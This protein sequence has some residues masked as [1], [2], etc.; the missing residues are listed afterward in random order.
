MA[1]AISTI[2]AVHDGQAADVLGVMEITL[3]ARLKR[4]DEAVERAKKHPCE[5]HRVWCLL[6]IA[7][8]EFKDG[9]LEPARRLLLE[10]SAASSTVADCPRRYTD[11]GSPLWEE[12]LQQVL[13]TES[14][15]NAIALVAISQ[16]SAG[17]PAEAAATARKLPDEESRASALLVVAHKQAETGHV[18]HARA[19]VAVAKA[20]ARKI[21]E[22]QEKAK[23]LAVIAVAEDKLGR[24]EESLR[25][26]AEALS[27]ANAILPCGSGSFTSQCLPTIAEAELAAGSVAEAAE[28][29]RAMPD[30]EKKRSLLEDIARR[31]EK[32]R[33]KV[34]STKLSD[35]AEKLPAP[36][37]DA[38]MTAALQYDAVGTLTNAGKYAEAIAKARQ[39]KDSRYKEWAY[40]SIASA[41][42][43]AKLMKELRETLADW[44][45]AAR[46]FDDPLIKEDAWRQITPYVAELRLARELQSTFE[47]RLVLARQLDA[48]GILV[49]SSAWFREQEVPALAHIAVDQA[50]FGRLDDALRT[51]DMI[52]DVHFKFLTLHAIM[53]DQPDNKPIDD[54]RRFLTAA[55][56][57]ARAD[58]ENRADDF[59]DIAEFQAANGFGAEASDSLDELLSIA[60]KMEDLGD[61]A[62][63]LCQVA[64]ARGGVPKHT[65]V[66]ANRISEQDKARARPI[67]REAV[68]SAKGIQNQTKR[69]RALREIIESQ[70]N[71]G[72]LAEATEM[73]RHIEDLD[74]R[75]ECLI[76]NVQ[77]HAEG[78]QARAIL[79]A[80]FGNAKSISN[81]D[82]R[83][84]AIRR[85]V[86]AAAEVHLFAEALSMARIMERGDEKSAALLT[87]A[88]AQSAAGMQQDA[89]RTF[90]DAIAVARGIDDP[91]KKPDA[92]REIAIALAKTPGQ[93]RSAIRSLL[94]GATKIRA[95]KE[96]TKRSK[97]KGILLC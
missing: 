44:S 34:E 95:R 25:T 79:A 8:A 31:Q 11:L 59:T 80:A 3:L 82:A 2:R 86:D 51:I 66:Q 32:S 42:S 77:Y 46:Q 61:R 45:A 78:D 22:A 85:I 27:A 23:V 18:D 92:L 4:F 29:C 84:R 41:Q 35:S 43:D 48:Q 50:R 16:A 10:A 89:R 57:A 12:G 71:A 70:Q 67:Y 47:E 9:K 90:A 62:L 24:K 83:D 15:P 1:D 75:V 69:Y 73:A 52:K 33:T 30:S 7:A 91:F 28:T 54:T 14:T 87:V 39:I 21:G 17:L 20:E 36:P 55:L 56:A 6:Y 74:A 94:R 63:A 97:G 40:S 68:A 13:V 96:G 93:P 37:P 72:L 64:L 38:A 81:I 19:N 49:P 60:R 88:K 26:F 58:V 76:W 65:L 53:R 5:Y